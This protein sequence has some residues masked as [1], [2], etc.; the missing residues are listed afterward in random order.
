MLDFGWCLS[1]FGL[2]DP[3]ASYY[4]WTGVGVGAGLLLVLV[5]GYW[6]FGWVRR[7]RP[8]RPG[9]RCREVKI[10]GERGDLYVTAS[11]LREFVERILFEFREA[12]LRSL[13]VREVRSMLALTVE[14]DVVP[15]TTLPALKDSIQERVLQEVHAKIGIE[16]KLEKVDVV[17][18]NMSAPKDKL[19]KQFDKIN[20][21]KGLE[22]DE[23]LEAEDQEPAGA[24]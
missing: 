13:E 3:D 2:D 12:A 10:A 14:I 8:R 5:A 22:L 16:G 4:F 15:E 23:A 7:K 11:A 24:C 21:E 9:R 20:R 18:H 19:A 1:W 17:V 6:A